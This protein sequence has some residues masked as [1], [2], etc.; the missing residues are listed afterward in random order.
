MVRLIHLVP[1]LPPEMCGVGDYATLVGGE[2]EALHG[3]V[4][5]AFIACGH[6]RSEAVINS[7]KRRDITGSCEPS[8]LWHAVNESSDGQTAGDTT[9]ILHYSGYGYAPSGAPTWLAEA[10]ERRPTG[11]SAC[12]IVTFFHEL[13]A[14]G[15]PWERAFW[16]SGRQ[17]AVARRIAQASDSLLTNR[18]Q[19]ARWLEAQTG[20]STGSVR[21]LPT[22]SNVGEVERLPD[23]P[24]RVPMAVLFGGVRFKQSFLT[25]Q[26]ADTIAA[27]RRLGVES[28]VDVGTPAQIDRARFHRA[29]IRVEQTGWLPAED[30]SPLFR[31]CQFALVDYFP[32]YAAKSGVLAAAAAH[33]APTI[34]PRDIRGNRD[35]LWS[36]KQYLELGAVAVEN[37]EANRRRLPTVSQSIYEWY[38]SHSINRHAAALAEVAGV[39]AEASGPAA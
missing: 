2:I 24:A 34:F 1:R 37:P 18:E 3:D 20:R 14:T 12:R 28:L 36:G 6:R 35:G 16:T 13:Y 19:S 23:W 5:C 33:G 39:R 32:E 8:A 25:R 31:R 9:I 26:V 22:C 27:C 15:R 17:Q 10:I 11:W 4:S 21:H 30:V 7:D 29:G 38:A